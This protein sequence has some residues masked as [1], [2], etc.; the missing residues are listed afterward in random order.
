MTNIR[1]NAS[2]ELTFSIKKVDGTALQKTDL[3]TLTL[4]LYDVETGGVINSRN[5]TS[6]LDTNGG[7]VASDCTGTVLFLAA[8]NPVIKSGRKVGELEPHGVALEF[9]AAA[10]IAGGADLRFTVERRA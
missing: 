9:T 8:D 7:T 1:E 5:Y 6:V 4:K 10:G 3:V 2:S